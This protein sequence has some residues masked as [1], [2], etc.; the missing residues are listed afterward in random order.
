MTTRQGGIIPPPTSATLAQAILKFE[1]TFEIADEDAIVTAFLLD[2]LK[3][4][5]TQGKQ[6]HDANIVATMQRYG[7]QWLFTH[8]TA[9]FTRYVPNISILPLIP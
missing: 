1:A 2:L 4:R 8:N 7:L 9:D 3:S 5:T 6:I